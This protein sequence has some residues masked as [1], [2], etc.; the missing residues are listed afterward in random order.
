MLCRVADSL[1]W[2]SRYLERAENQARFIDVTS[3][4]ALG[5]RGREDDLWSS[6]LHAGGDVTNFQ[7]R[8][9]TTRREDVI[10][11]LLFDRQNPNSVVSCLA[12]ARENARSI[13]ENLTTPM[14]E[15][16]N[17]F[18]LRVRR[19]AADSAQVLKQ[20]YPFLEQIKRSAHQVIGV[21]AATWSR[22]EAWHFSTI[23]YQ[24]ERADKTSRILDV[25]Y[26]ILL[27]NPAHVGS[28]VD[29]VQWGALLESTGGLQMYRRAHG[30]I[31]PTNVLDFM[32]LNPR[33][34]RSLRCCVREAEASLRAISG[35]PAHTFSNPAEQLLGQMNS[36]LNYARASDIISGGL[37]QFIDDFQGR[38]NQAGLAVAES[39]FRVAAHESRAV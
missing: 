30:R 11:Y 33:F 7:E 29:V 31:L 14:W 13:R 39:F 5:F 26:F 10:R 1:F 3:N 32:I 8:Y 28:Q 15:S 25:K 4:I 19:A 27:P 12:A 17:R 16:V 38:V 6:L 23:G 9:T 35:T 20:P 37:H 34:P 36:Q 22:G 24:L 21:T 2:M 18:Y